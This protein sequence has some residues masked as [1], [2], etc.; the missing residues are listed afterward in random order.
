MTC[1]LDSF[2]NNDPVFEVYGHV[3][4]R[5]ANLFS[6]DCLVKSENSK[7]FGTTVYWFHKL[8]E[9]ISKFN[10]VWRV[11][12]QNEFLITDLSF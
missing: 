7:H 2:I 3:R 4:H 10:V 12:R 5:W 11:S 8:R 6:Y 1:K 9:L